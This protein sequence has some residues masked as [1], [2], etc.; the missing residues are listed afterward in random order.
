MG[1]KTLPPRE[2]LVDDYTGEEI[3]TAAW[4]ITNNAG[5]RYDFRSCTNLFKCMLEKPE[6]LGFLT[7]DFFR[8]H[9]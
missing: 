5:E 8:R 6:V 2:V 9:V 1:M 7:P 4:S 3:Q